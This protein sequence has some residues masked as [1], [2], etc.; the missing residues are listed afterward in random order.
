MEVPEMEE[1][2]ANPILEK[3]TLLLENQMKM[4]SM[5]TA[6]SS[7]NSPDLSG[8]FEKL[9]TVIERLDGKVGEQGMAID[10][11]SKPKKPRK[12]P[13]IDRG[14]DGMVA[15]VDGIPVTRDAEGRLAGLAEAP[16]EE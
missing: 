15:A 12:A 3:I 5:N 13:K 6:S 8:V 10:G 4:L 16:P 11:L 1:M 9:A 2:P 7:T 14:P